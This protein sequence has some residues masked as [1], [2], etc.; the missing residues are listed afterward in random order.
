MDC[1]KRFSN[2]TTGKRAEQKSYREKGETN[3]KTKFKGTAR[4]RFSN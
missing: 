2:N 1:R 4:K 3:E